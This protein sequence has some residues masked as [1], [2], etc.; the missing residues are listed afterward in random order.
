M[1]A[2]VRW[3]HTQN[4]V[5][6]SRNIG[7]PRS[8]I[9]NDES[10]APPVGTAMA[11]SPIVKIGGVRATVLDAGLAPGFIG[12]YQINVQV[13]ADTLPGESPLW[14]GDQPDE[15]IYAPPVAE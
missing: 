13:P 3:H 2:P 7:S 10:A 4:R 1:A 5:A 14:F 12:L 8:R 11:E 15:P 6:E 9:P